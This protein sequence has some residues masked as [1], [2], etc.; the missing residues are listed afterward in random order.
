MPKQLDAT[1]SSLD[2]TYSSLYS[3]LSGGDGVIG[4]CLGYVKFGI[5]SAR[6]WS[7]VGENLFTSISGKRDM[8]MTPMD[9]YASITPDCNKFGVSVATDQ[10]SMKIHWTK[11]WDIWPSYNEEDGDY[12][13]L[14][15]PHDQLDVHCTVGDSLMSNIKTWQ[16]MA[17]VHVTVPE[18]EVTAG[19]SIQLYDIWSTRTKRLLLMFMFRKYGFSQ[20]KQQW[21][22]GTFPGTYYWGKS[23]VKDSMLNK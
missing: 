13:G 11:N 1:Y 23:A 10:A 18:E 22:S 6:S 3:K 15:N 14:H 21:T 16:A 4:A 9:F 17:G 12:A 8:M 20:R 2:V 19:I 5:L 7:L